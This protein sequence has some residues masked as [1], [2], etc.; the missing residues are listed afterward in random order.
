MQPLEVTKEELL[1]LLK[2]VVDVVEKDD[3]YGCSLQYEASSEP[4]KFL[5]LAMVRVGN[6][7]GSQGGMLVVAHPTEA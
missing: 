6:S 3:S 4:G 7:D 1:Q 2:T 5:A